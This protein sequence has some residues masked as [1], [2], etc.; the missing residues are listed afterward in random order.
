MPSVA[1]AQASWRPEIVVGV[2]VTANVQFD[3][4]DANETA[5]GGQTRTLFKS[6][7][8]MEASPGVEAGVRLAVARRLQFE[9]SLTFSR[10]RLATHITADAEAGDVTITEPITHYAVRAGLSHRVAD[11]L[12]GAVSPFIA[13]GIGY[14]RQ[15]HDGNVLVEGGPIYYVGGGLDFRFDRAGRGSKFSGIRVDAGETF[16]TKGLTLDSTTRAA[17][18]IGAAVIMRF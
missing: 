1:G 6:S 8:E 5:F 15:L 11:W 12:S 9:S 14:L 4:A 17:P 7:S 10:T 3:P 18:A 13:G 2:R 16:F